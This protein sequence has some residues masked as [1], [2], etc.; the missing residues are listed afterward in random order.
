MEEKYSTE[1]STLP[2]RL[3]VSS[4]EYDMSGLANK[5]ALR[6]YSGCTIEYAQLNNLGHFAVGAEGLTKGL[7]SVFRT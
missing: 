1:K 6:Q 4:G 3:F 5:M 2:V 7:V